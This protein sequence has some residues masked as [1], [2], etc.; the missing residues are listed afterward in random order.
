M[1]EQMTNRERIYATCRKEE[2][3]RFPVWM[4]MANDT[5]KNSQPEPYRSMT[6]IGLL[7]EAG[8]DLMLGCHV[9]VN[10][11]NP[12]VTIKRID[13]G[14][15]KITI[16]STPDGELKAITLF[17][18][19]TQSTHPFKY[20]VENKEDLKKA[21]WLFK[22][23]TYSVKKEDIKAAQ[24]RKKQFEKDD[25][26][27]TS[28]IGPS[29]FMECVENLCGPINSVYLQ[30][31]EPELFN[32]LIEEMHQNQI[33]HLKTRLPYCPADSF[34]MTENTSTSLI[35][36]DQFKQFCMH[37]LKEY[38]QM[39]LDHGIIPVHHMCGTLNALLELIDEL[40]AMVNEA[41]TTYPL[42][43]VS[44]AEGRKRMPSKA[45]IGGTNATLWMEDEDAIV[46]AVAEDL[47]KCENRLG[48]FLTSAGVLTPLSSMGKT[49][50]VIERLKELHC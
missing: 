12:D 48:I 35:S 4:K 28:G 16:F 44:L 26:F 36:P 34:W 21:M 33:R 49:K 20:A 30:M 40:P 37:K 7:K 1:K 3:D 18:E 46:Q 14:N 8:S 42:G 39:I 43:D 50:R 22:N 9:K 45:L 32:A 15:E 47:E 38:G 17:D 31:D 11:S 23:K 6:G 13:N 25:V 24:E 2:V 27:T 10:A 5:W 41:Y 19:A 29:P